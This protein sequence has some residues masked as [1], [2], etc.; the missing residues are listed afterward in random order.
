MPLPVEHLTAFGFPPETLEAW[1]R[2]GIERLLPLQEQALREHGFLHDRHLLV[3]APTSSG[4]TFVAE[5]AAM[6]H[7]D[8]GRRVVYLVPTRRSRRRS[9]A[10]SRACALRWATARPSPRASAPTRTARSSRDG[11]ISSWPFTKR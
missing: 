8:R 5:M 10:P 1:R 11:T 7:L 3:S 6:R 4:K 9:S 2:Q